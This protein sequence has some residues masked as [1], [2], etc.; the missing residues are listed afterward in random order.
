MGNRTAKF[1]SALVGSIIAGAPLAAVSQN[2]PTPPSTGKCGQRLSCLAKGRRAAGPALVFSRRARDQAA[3]L[4]SARRRRQGH[5]KRAGAP[6]TPEAD[7]PA[8][9]ALGPGR[10][11][12][13]SDA[14]EHA[15]VKSRRRAAPTQQAASPSADVTRSS[16][17]SPRAG[18]MPPRRPPRRSRSSRRPHL[19]GGRT[20]EREAGEVPCPD[21]AGRGRRTADKPT[22]SLQMLLLVIGG[23]LALAGLLA[24]VDLSLRWWTRA[25]P[26]QPIAASTGTSAGRP[27]TAARPGSREPTPRVA[28]QP[29]PVDFDA[30]RPWKPRRSPH[31]QR[32]DQP[33]RCAGPSRRGCDSRA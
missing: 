30:M 29:R 24:S 25:R 22:G 15:T 4:V 18:P 11:C 9:A 6:D 16:P 20:A 10:A 3:V 1:I 5:A 28:R 23:A 19:R 17:P 27:M 33:D 31:L 7:S 14:A 32:H 8:A 21:G 2:A 26:A 13:I 12:R